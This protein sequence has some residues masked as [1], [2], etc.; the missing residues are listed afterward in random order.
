MQ[1]NKNRWTTK[2]RLPSL[3]Q[4]NATI[5][6]NMSYRVARLYGVTKDAEWSCV[7]V[8]DNYYEL[9]AEY[10]IKSFVPIT[11]KNKVITIGKKQH[12]QQRQ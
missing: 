6:L 7:P 2:I 11:K 8:G 3:T 9:W 10:E 12:F 4:E 1:P 5:F